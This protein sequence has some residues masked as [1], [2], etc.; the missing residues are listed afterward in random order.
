MPG[1][2]SW[3]SSKSR[4]KTISG[5]DSG[6][7]KPGAF[8]LFMIETPS[9]TT[10]SDTHRVSRRRVA[11]HGAQALV[12]RRT[13]TALTLLHHAEPDSGR[14]AVESTVH[15][16]S[17]GVA[18]KSDA[19]VRVG[20]AFVTGGDARL[21]GFWLRFR[22]RLRR[23]TARQQHESEKCETVHRSSLTVFS[24]KPPFTF[25]RRPSSPP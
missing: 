17:A 4:K 3:S 7:K 18:V 19:A 11:A 25:A 14:P 5:S 20:D 23:L 9:E 2:V 22:R 12:V 15:R 16:D 13:G 6:S 21:Q 8:V 24:T 1:S 10:R